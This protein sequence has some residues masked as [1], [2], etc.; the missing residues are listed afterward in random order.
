MDLL[1]VITKPTRITDTS[2]TLID[3]IFISSR[4]QQDYHSGFIISDMSDHLPTFVKFRYVE[5]DIKQQMEISYRKINETN[6]QAMN[7]DLKGYN[8]EELLEGTKTDE[9]FH[10]LHLIVLESMNKHMP[11]KTRKLAKKVQ[12]NEPWLTKGIKRSIDKQK[13]LY[14]KTLNKEAT[15]KDNIKYKT[16]RNTIQRVKRKAK[17]TYYQ[18][19][20]KEYKNETRKLW[21]VI[22]VGNS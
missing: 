6:I 4:I 9:A 8:W 21:N 17:M 2:A 10:I 14:R 18:G 13:Q 15:E 20:C 12:S 11:E 5:Y 19:K 1:P 7:E 3:N 22:Q 16:N